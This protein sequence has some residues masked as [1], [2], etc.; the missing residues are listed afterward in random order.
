[1]EKKQE[2]PSPETPFLPTVELEGITKKI[3]GYHGTQYNACEKLLAL[4]WE[5]NLAEIR[6]ACVERLAKIASEIPYDPHADNPFHVYDLAEKTISAMEASNLWFE[7]TQR[8][9]VWYLSQ[10]SCF[11]GVRPI[12]F[13][14]ALLRGMQESWERFPQRHGAIYGAIKRKPEWYWAPSVPGYLEQ[15]L[16]SDNWTLV[17][18]A[19]EL[20]CIAEDTSF[21]PQVVDLSRKAG[22]DKEKAEDFKTRDV[23]RFATAKMRGVLQEATRHL[24]LCKTE[25]RSDI[26]DFQVVV[27]QAL[28]KIGGLKTLPE[29]ALNC[30]EAI[31]PEM[32]FAVS[33]EV[34]HEGGDNPFSQPDPIQEVLKSFNF[35]VTVDGTSF[36]KGGQHWNSN[37]TERFIGVHPPYRVTHKVCTEKVKGTTRKTIR[38]RVIVWHTT[39]NEEGKPC[40]ENIGT[41]TR[42][43][44]RAEKEKRPLE[45]Y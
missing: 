40:Q 22:E 26:V 43:I 9:L 2:A 4:I 31:P 36:E 41:L 14:L 15:S 8:M 28:R 23:S 5:Y 24:L 20:I 34:E 25:E 19:L 37:F 16:A 45:T 21:L 1:M 12:E 3:E 10:E 29:V 13:A 11:V 7:P 38:V 42:Y 18:R 44:H 27:A 35:V 32:D 17:E 6:T 30:P 39:V 33:M